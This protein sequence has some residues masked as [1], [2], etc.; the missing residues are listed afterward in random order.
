LA[1]AR[2]R[3]QQAGWRNVE[4][5]LSDAATF[6]WPP[7]VDGVVATYALGIVPNLDDVLRRAAAALGP[8]RRIVVL[9]LKVRGGWPRW[10]LRA[11]VTLVRPFGVTL[12]DAERRP[13]E[14]MRRHLES[15]D[16]RERY[17]GTTYV[18]IGEAGPR[19]G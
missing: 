8:G 10:V 5:V 18:A 6:A 2:R 13:W 7:R 15:V 11:V 1:Q 4:L 14:S 12:A 19:A 3:V 16:V 9:D 17:L